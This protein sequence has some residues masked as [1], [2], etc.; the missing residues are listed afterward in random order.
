MSNFLFFEIMKLKY[1]L[2]LQKSY[3]KEKKMEV[4]LNGEVDVYSIGNFICFIK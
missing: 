2:Y 1:L 4:V 3:R